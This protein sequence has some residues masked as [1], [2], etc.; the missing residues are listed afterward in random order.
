MVSY[1][2]LGIFRAGFGPVVHG[3]RCAKAKCVF[4]DD[5]GVVSLGFPVVFGILHGDAGVPQQVA[6]VQGR[7][8]GSTE[9]IGQVKRLVILLK[10]ANFSCACSILTVSAL[11]Q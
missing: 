3:V 1:L 9:T 4:V 6:E 10:V 5:V 8:C 2:R 11:W 7:G